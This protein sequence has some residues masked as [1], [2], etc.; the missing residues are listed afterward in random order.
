M[1]FSG[2]AAQH[3]EETQSAADKHGDNKASEHLAVCFVQSVCGNFFLYQPE[4]LQLY[5]QGASHSMLAVDNIH[6]W[7]DA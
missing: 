4:G 7:V 5:Q 6:S 2:N 3:F 1:C